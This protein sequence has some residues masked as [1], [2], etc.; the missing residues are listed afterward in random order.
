MTRLL[1]RKA[2]MNAQFTSLPRVH[3]EA[4]LKEFREKPRGKI[5]R[6]A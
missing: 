2:E 4:E 3:D 1:Q 6:A 5:D